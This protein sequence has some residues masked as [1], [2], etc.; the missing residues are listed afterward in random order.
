MGTYL[1]YCVVCTCCVHMLPWDPFG[2]GNGNGNGHLAAHDMRVCASLERAER[3]RHCQREPRRPWIICTC[4]VR[5]TQYVPARRHLVREV[6]HVRLSLYYP[7]LNA[8]DGGGPTHLMASPRPGVTGDSGAR[9][10]HLYRGICRFQTE[11]FLIPTSS[12][13]PRS[14]RLVFNAW[15]STPSNQLLARISTNRNTANRRGTCTS[16]LPVGDPTPLPNLGRDVLKRVQDTPTSASLVHVPRAQHV[17][18][19]L[20]FGGVDTPPTAGDP[21][22]V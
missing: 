20:L 12:R 21:W 2:Q 8:G 15:C 13:T 5:T 18:R 10:T 16:A 9:A 14:R 19:H 17:S 3:P 22:T 4:H 11:R 7:V 1:A 6:L